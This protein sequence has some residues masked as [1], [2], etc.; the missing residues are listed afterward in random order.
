MSHMQSVIEEH[1]TWQPAAHRWRSKILPLIQTPASLL[2]LLVLTLSAHAEE[3]DNEG[4][5][6][7]PVAPV[8]VELDILEPDI[9]LD[10]T[11]EEIGRIRGQARNPLPPGFRL[12]GL[13]SWQLGMRYSHSVI[14]YSKIEDCFRL[15]WVRIALRTTKLEVYLASEI[16]P[17]SC[18]FRENMAHEMQHVD[19]LRNSA[20][21]QHRQLR[22][23]L[24][25][26]ELL[27]PIKATDVDAAVAEYGIRLATLIA[28]IR[29]P[30][31]AEITRRDAALDTAASYRALTNR[32]PPG[33]E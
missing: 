20:R 12:N 15:R 17:G 16:P 22:E 7:A 10:R 9:I 26:H 14:E 8:T 32:C 2:L 5:P 18:R 24:S 29:D 1:S 4:C 21:E 23:T 25:G 27:K 33:S 19:V 13:T 30:L 28:E 11:R 31:M 3:A 6:A